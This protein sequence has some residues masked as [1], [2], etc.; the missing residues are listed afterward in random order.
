[1]NEVGLIGAW[2]LWSSG[3]LESNIT[4]CRTSILWLGRVGKL[5][6]L[7]AAMA[8][9]AEI[10][11]P[12]RLRQFGE[13]LHGVLS[14]ETIGKHFRDGIMWYGYIFKIFSDE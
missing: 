14:Q 9:L 1:M 8:I 2:T 13:S 7:V 6:Q 4:L 12:E 5:V 11:G 3:Q 10:V